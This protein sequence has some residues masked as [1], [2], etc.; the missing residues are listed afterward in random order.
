M[1]K[2]L[3]LIVV[4]GIARASW[5]QTDQASWANLSALQTG[6]KIQIVDMNSKKHPGT[7]ASVSDGAISYRDAAGHETMQKPDVRSVKLMAN[8]HRLQNAAI[9]GALGAGAGA[10]IAAAKFHPCSPSQFLCIQP[11][12]RGGMA[13]IGAVVGLAGGAVVGALLPS[14]K[15]IYRATSH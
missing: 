10:G 9:G 13:G 14:H 2:I 4:V 6:Q 3:F 12:G 15:M 1:R 7:F 11:I 8:R 5:A